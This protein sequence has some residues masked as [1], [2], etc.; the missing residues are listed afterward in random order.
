M[1]PEKIALRATTRA[2]GPIAG[3]VGVALACA[4][5]A[6]A[7]PSASH[8]ETAPPEP[9]SMTIANSH[10][11]IRIYRP[12]A[13]QPFYTGQRFNRGGIIAAVETG[14]RVFFG[15][16]RDDFQA[17]QHDAIT[18][19]ADEFDIENPPGYAEAGIGGVFV[20]IGVG[21]LR[22]TAAEGYRFW[23]TYP[24]ADA[25][26]W[27]T[28]TQA[29][30]ARFRH[31]LRTAEGYA[32][33]LTKTIELSPDEP[34]FTLRYELVNTGVRPLSTL[35]YHHNFC[36]FDGVREVGPDWS[37]KFGYAPEVREGRPSEFAALEGNVLR[38]VQPLPAGKSFWTSLSG[39]ADP[40]VHRIHI[41]HATTGD[42]I[43]IAGDQPIEKLNVW[44]AHRTVCPEPFV[45]ISLE[46][47]AKKSWTTTYRFVVRAPTP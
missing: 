18:G 41:R 31:L 24:V 12:D 14:G 34:A 29:G 44:S 5:R 10:L 45:R 35:H 13:D 38:F 11:R 36:V 28:E 20:K 22:R 7:P 19:P 46:P 16:W 39:A 27:E 15:P 30:S 2:A 1:I 17:T 32:Y 25:G 3:L 43:E 9:P 26:Q 40:A 42:V 8:R 4:A 6:D 33:E 21:A 37:V 23:E 47:G